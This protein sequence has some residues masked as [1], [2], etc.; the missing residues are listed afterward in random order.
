[1]NENLC[2]TITTCVLTAGACFISYE[3]INS[4]TPFLCEYDI[5]SKKVRFGMNGGNPIVFENTNE[6]QNNSQNTISTDNRNIKKGDVL[7]T[8][9]KINFD[10]KSLN[11]EQSN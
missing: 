8:D 3:V 2:K 4:K 1:M 6:I 7:G 11:H 10:E 5:E 9:S